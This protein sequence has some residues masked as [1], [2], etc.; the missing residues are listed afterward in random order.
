M[1]SF[2]DFVNQIYLDVPGCNELIIEQQLQNATTDFLRDSEV[3]VYEHDPIDIVSGTGDYALSIDYD[4]TIQRIK[5][6]CL[7][8]SATDR[9]SGAM[10]PYEYKLVEEWTFRFLHTPTASQTDGLKI[11]LILRPVFGE[12]VDVPE[13]IWD[14]YAKGIIAKTKANLM[15]MSKKPWTD[16]RLAAFHEGI[17]QGVRAEA[18]REKYA[19]C[20][21]VSLRMTTPFFG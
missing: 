2:D 8:T 7:N 21:D 6:A 15:S 14:R 10:Y 16:H 18:I 13:W 3:W 1:N 11:D 20:K 9:T 5:Q 19:E 4:A 17:Y 12:A